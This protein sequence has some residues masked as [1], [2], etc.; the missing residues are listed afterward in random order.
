MGG[1]WSAVCRACVVF[2]WPQQDCTHCVS[3]SWGVKRTKP[4]PPPSNPPNPTAGDG[5]GE[6]AL[7]ELAGLD[8]AITGTLVERTLQRGEE[9]VGGVCVGESGC[10]SE[11]VRVWCMSASSRQPHRLSSNHQPTSQPIAPPPPKKKVASA[12]ARF[13]AANAR[14]A[15][16]RK[17]PA[18][19]E[20]GAKPEDLLRMH[21]VGLGSGGKGCGRKF[22]SINPAA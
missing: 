8:K 5:G 18:R 6:G 11:S 19:Q 14:A 20:R 21:E 4:I 15:A 3:S 10:R 13:E 1:L 9:Q 7:D 12:E 16:G 2:V 22:A 17:G